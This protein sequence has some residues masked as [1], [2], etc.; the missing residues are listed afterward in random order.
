MGSRAV[1][2][3]GGQQ[4]WELTVQR[5]VGRANAIVKRCA[6]VSRQRNRFVLQR[7]DFRGL[8]NGGGRCG[9]RF[10]SPC[11]RI[12]A[13]AQS[14]SPLRQ[15]LSARR[16]PSVSRITA[17]S[18]SGGV[19]STAMTIREYWSRRGAWLRPLWYIA[20]V[21]FFYCGYLSLHPHNPIMLY[22]L[23]AASLL[24]AAAHLVGLK[25]IPCPRCRKEMGL[26]TTRPASRRMM[27]KPVHCKSC[28]VDIDEPMRV[29]AI[30]SP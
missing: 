10:T 2:I 17:K 14:P 9:E 29:S 27:G 18:K 21:N 22:G 16:S 24:L 28:G 23:E 8:V 6:L 20:A 1:G 13:V 5:R 12:R 11:N 26:V 19:A 25:R 30:G 3:G 7:F 4:A 15:R